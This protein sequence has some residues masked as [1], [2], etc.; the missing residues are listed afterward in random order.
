MVQTYIF[1]KNCAEK[2]K[3][4]N[5]S[6]VSH[7]PPLRSAFSSAQIRP[8]VSAMVRNGGNS[9]CDSKTN[10]I[11]SWL[12][13]LPLF[14]WLLTTL[15]YRTNS[16]RASDSKTNVIQALSTDCSSSCIDPT[17]TAQLLPSFPA[18]IERSVLI[19]TMFVARYASSFLYFQIIFFWIIMLFVAVC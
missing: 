19:G 2:Q 6:Y 4:K 10:A 16:E 18:S 11:C 7:R 5:R 13:S 14:S 9:S 15:F 3:K 17:S 12:A 1:F 8:A